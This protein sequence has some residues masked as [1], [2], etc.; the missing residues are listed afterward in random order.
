MADITVKRTSETTFHV[1]VKTGVDQTVHD[2]TATSSDVQR[3]GGSA[4]PE[5]L[6]KESFEFLLEREPK[7]SILRSFQLTVI[8]RYFPE[9]P[10]EIRRRLGEG[11]S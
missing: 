3:Y 1:K 11:P 2:V 6:I 7:E 9:Y 8:E 10:I 5:R 4:S